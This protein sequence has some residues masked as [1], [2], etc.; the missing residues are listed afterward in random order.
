MNGKI[1]SFRLFVFLYSYLEF[2]MLCLNDF[3]ALQVLSCE[4]N[5]ILGIQV[6]HELYSR[7]F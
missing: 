5:L 2:S 6:V 1:I 7:L 4:G 3:S